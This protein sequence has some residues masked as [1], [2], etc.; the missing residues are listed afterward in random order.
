[1]G[2]A[3]GADP[4]LATLMSVEAG[5]G[6]RRRQIVQQRDPCMVLD[7]KP[8][9]RS[10]HEET[11]A[12]AAQLVDEG[13]L[14]GARTNVLEHRIAVAERQRMASVSIRCHTIW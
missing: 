12:D 5:H 4:G 6:N 9:V 2:Q 7:G 11:A 10:C 3:S 13:G 8:P 14:R 1:M